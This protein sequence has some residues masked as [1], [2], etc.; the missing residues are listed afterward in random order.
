MLDLIWLQQ[1]FWSI[2]TPHTACAEEVARLCS[3]SLVLIFASSCL[4]LFNI[5][6]KD[7]VLLPKRCQ[8]K[9]I[10]LRHVIPTFQ[11]ILLVIF[12]S[13]NCVRS[14]TTLF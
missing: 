13:F 11:Y 1:G 6:L 3:S 4:E 12:V 10:Y 7:L 14:K 2:S 9:I 5:H 8:T